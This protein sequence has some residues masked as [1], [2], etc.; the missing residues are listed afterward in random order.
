MTVLTRFTRADVWRLHHD[1]HDETM[2]TMWEA[3]VVIVA[4]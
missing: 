3:K 2:G 1:G 4:S